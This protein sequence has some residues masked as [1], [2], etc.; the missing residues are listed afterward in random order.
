M[1]N[2]LERMRRRLVVLFSLNTEEELVAFEEY[3]KGM[4]IRHKKL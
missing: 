3:R 1:M 4:F 2:C